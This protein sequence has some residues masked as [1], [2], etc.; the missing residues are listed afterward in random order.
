MSDATE[1]L[2]AR[3]GFLVPLNK[4][5]GDR[6]NRL[7]QSSEMVKLKKKQTLFKQGERDDFTYYLIDGEIEMYADESLIKHVAGGDASSFQPLAQLQPRQMSAVA[8]TA[9]QV[10]QV[11][12][13][14][15]DQLLSMDDAPA[16][17][18]GGSGM[19]VEEMEADQGGDW[20]MTLLQS[21]LFTRIPPSNIQ[22]LLDTLETVSAEV[23]EEIIKQG[24]PGEYYFAIQSGA[25][26]VVRTGSNNREIKLADLDS[27]ATFGEEALI[28]GAKRNATV[29]MTRAGELARLTKDDFTRLIKAPLLNT[30]SREEADKK[31]AAGGRWL[32]VRFEDEHA[33]NGIAG[34]LN[35]PHG[36]LRTR[37]DELDP[38][39]AYIAYCDTGG[40]SSA[41]AFL[42]AER[43]FDVGFVEGGAVTEPIPEPPASP[44]P[45]KKKPAAKK[46]P[47][48][49]DPPRAKPAKPAPAAKAAKPAAASTPPAAKAEAAAKS[50]DSDAVLEANALASSL[51]AEREKAQLIIDKA[52]KMMAEA[53]AMKQEAERVVATK[54]AE[55]RARVDAETEKLREKLNEAQRLKESL[56]AQQQAAEDDAAAREREIEERVTALESATREK[57]AE[58]EQRLESLYQKQTEQIESLQA[59]KESEL[60]A[61]FDTELEAERSKLEQEKQRTSAELE[62]AEAARQ[63]ALA[64]KEAEVRAQLSNEL[65]AERSKFEKE[66]LRAT[67]E[68]ENAREERRQALAAKEAATAE[69]QAAIE[70][71]KEQQAALQQEQQAALAEERQRLK[72]EAERIE[73]MRDEATRAR[74]AAEAAKT[75]AEAALAEAR[76]RKPD[77]GSASDDLEIIE[78]EQRAS[79]ADAEL[80][81]A[82]KVETVVNEAARDNE[83][84]LERTYDTAN[85]INMLLEKELNDFVGEQDEM[86]NSTLQRE[87]LS[88]QKEMLDRIKAR[89]A[90][91]A[92]SVEDRNQSL[93]DEIAAQ[94]KKD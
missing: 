56:A 68:L 74:E 20:L 13:G 36:M 54:L 49:K 77:T 1:A 14:L 82:I 34:S 75:Q 40:R 15:L 32:D 39:T 2:E 88:R 52:E 70:Q 45:A 64:A 43:G 12:R 19:E 58:E 48:K 28:S 72:T 93:L 60:R 4:L 83:D 10:L 23:G 84:E 51:N 92:A 30:M 86:Q 55:E 69:A 33:H 66:F 62:K 18:I 80:K 35:I 79:A 6:Q 41:A 24:E 63:E 16:E 21:E 31:I 5:P 91:Q 90:Q 27:G 57:L 37:L 11:N 26:E 89:A 53:E 85:E 3:L 8:K 44:A 61:K 38:E 7:L 67:E 25:C 17:P 42:L 73:A 50:S 22:A 71:F 59:E 87:V 9:C 29:R 76:E 78:I 65:A 47:D 94:L 46:A 81:E